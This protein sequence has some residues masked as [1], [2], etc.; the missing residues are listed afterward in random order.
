MTD[1]KVGDIY[2]TDGIEWRII[3]IQGNM[4]FGINF[5]GQVI[6]IKVGA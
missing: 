6:H 2:K 3:S 1:L 4:A 5:N